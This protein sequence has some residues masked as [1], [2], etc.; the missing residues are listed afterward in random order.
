MKQLLL[1]SEP[2]MAYAMYTSKL[3]ES[4]RKADPQ[5]AQKLY[6]LCNAAVRARLG[7]ASVRDIAHSD[8]WSAQCAALEALKA[9]GVVDRN[10]HLS[11]VGAAVSVRV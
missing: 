2:W 3:L 11:N 1:K 10:K 8:V 4:T 9:V 5:R 7:I 6:A